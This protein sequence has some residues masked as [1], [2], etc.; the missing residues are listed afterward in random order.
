MVH[1]NSCNDS[2]LFT[3]G[4]Q[5]DHYSSLRFRAVSI[6]NLL[7][8]E[9]RAHTVMP[10]ERMRNP[11]WAEVDDSAGKLL[12]FNG[13]SMV[14]KVWDLVTYEQL[15]TMSALGVQ[16]I[17]VSSGVVVVGGLSSKG[18][19]RVKVVDACSGKAL[20]SLRAASDGLFTLVDF[21]DGKVIAKQERDPYCITDVWQ[22]SF[23]IIFRLSGAQAGLLDGARHRRGE[24][25]LVVHIP[26]P[27]RLPRVAAPAAAGRRVGPRWQSLLQLCGKRRRRA[28]LS[29]HHLGGRAHRLCLRHA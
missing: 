28:P 10:S 16:R 6:P 17:T 9:P 3:A 14:Y 21:C 15:F 26:P 24:R 7:K 19:A 29:H 5:H 4:R 23:F 8:R 25:A 11:S 1:Y 22:V 13:Y 18:V 27:A 2:L 20:A 12:T